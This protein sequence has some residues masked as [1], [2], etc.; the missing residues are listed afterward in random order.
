MPFTASSAISANFHA[1][2]K[3]WNF[4]GAI[5]GM[6]AFSRP[7]QAV[8]IAQWSQPGQNKK[9]WRAFAGAHTEEAL[10]KLVADLKLQSDRP[11]R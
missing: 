5:N 1:L 2:L 8:C 7:N 6:H 3:N 4:A 11:K 9:T 10:L